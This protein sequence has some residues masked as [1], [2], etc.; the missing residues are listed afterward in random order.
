MQQ[1]DA[2]SLAL[3]F[4]AFFCVGNI[5]IRMHRRLFLNWC[6]HIWMLCMVYWAFAC[7]IIK[8]QAQNCAA[9]GPEVVKC[10]SE[11]NKSMSTATAAAPAPANRLRNI[12]GP[13]TFVH[14]YPKLYDKMWK[15]LE[16]RAG[17]N[18]VFIYRN[19]C[20]Q[21]GLIFFKNKYI[22]FFSFDPPNKHFRDVKVYWIIIS[23]TFFSLDLSLSACNWK[24]AKRNRNKN[25]RHILY[26]I[27]SSVY[28]LREAFLCSVWVWVHC[29]RCNHCF[30]QYIYIFYSRYF[31]NFI[32]VRCLVFWFSCVCALQRVEMMMENRS[33]YL[34]SIKQ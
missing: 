33:W 7:T 8:I 30:N 12:I 28:L 24:A 29:T 22:Y 32:A 21:F 13:I 26:F 5:Y 20:V 18:N 10:C 3:L 9:D 2:I 11:R 23:I 1:N 27:L 19:V 34:T 6:S 17:E 15:N 14:I 16:G 4:L 25:Y 31:P